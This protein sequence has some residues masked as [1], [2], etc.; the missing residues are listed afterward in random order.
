MT[1]S[2]Y[3]AAIARID[4]LWGAEI[5]S[6]AGTELE[7]LVALVAAYENE[8]YPIS[9]PEPIKGIRNADE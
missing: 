3:T 4:V 1:E 7:V 5:G 6:P 8:H 9:P 2:E